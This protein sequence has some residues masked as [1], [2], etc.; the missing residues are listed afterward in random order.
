VI[1]PPIRAVT[2]GI[3]EPHPISPKVVERTAGRLRQAAA[4][5][6]TA[7]FDVQTMRLSTRPMLEDLAETNSAEIIEYAARL[8]ESLDSV[9]VA[10][11][12]V[13]PLRS[14]GRVSNSSGS[15]HSS[16]FW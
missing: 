14:G 7:G 11:C 2:L 4:A 8:Q 12:S 9:G 1:R 5:F 6:T 13:A 16:T 3:A 10:F 15:T